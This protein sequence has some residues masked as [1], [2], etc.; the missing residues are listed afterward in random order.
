M[1]IQF[2][3]QTFKIDGEPGVDVL[4]AAFSGI[5]HRWLEMMDMARFKI[6]SVNFQSL[7]VKKIKGRDK[8]LFVKWE[9]NVTKDGK[10]VPGIT[11]GSDDAIAVLYVLKCGRKRK[12]VIVK[13]ARVPTG[14]P[15]F[16]ELPAGV[17]D[18]DGNFV[19]AMLR[20]I[21]EELHIKVSA[22]KL[23][24]LS[25]LAGHKDG[26]FMSPGRCTERIVLF[27]VE[28]ECDEARFAELEGRRTGLADENEYLTV[29]V[30]DLNRLYSIPDAKTIAA[31]GLYKHH[32]LNRRA[33]KRAK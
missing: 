31:V 2:K 30:V 10:F 1:L 16:V 13:Q 19:S 21:E 18:G 24:C 5:F 17:F 8:I 15:D 9:A 33:R 20:E 32:V 22:D 12:A 25:D 29:D 28:E 26:M 11:F 14:D 6:E 7:D 27:Y 3:D 4:R 23:Q